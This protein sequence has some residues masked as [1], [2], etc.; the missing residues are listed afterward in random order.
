MES[1]EYNQKSSYKHNS[2]KDEEITVGD[3]KMNLSEFFNNPKVKAFKQMHGIEFSGEWEI[4][5]TENAQIFNDLNIPKGRIELGFENDILSLSELGYSSRKAKN[6][7]IKVI[8]MEGNYQDDKAKYIEVSLLDYETFNFSSSQY[9]FSEKPVNIMMFENMETKDM[10]Q[11]NVSI[12]LDLSAMIHFIQ[13]EAKARHNSQIHSIDDVPLQFHLT[14]SDCGFEVKSTLYKDFRDL[15]KKTINYSVLLTFVA[16]IHLYSIAKMIKLC[17]DSPT[18]AS[19]ISLITIGFILIWDTYICL[20]HLFTALRIEKLFH[21]FIMPTFW[22]FILFSIFETKLLII[23][24]KARYGNLYQNE[25]QSRRALAN[26]YFKLYTGMVIILYLL[27]EY[28]LSN[29]FVLVMSL[30]LVPQIIHN[31]MKGGRIEFDQN[32][33]FNIIGLR[34]LLPLYF[35]GCPENLMLLR[36]SF[37]FCS[38][39]IAIVGVQVLLVYYQSIYGS[40]FFVPSRFLPK[41]YNYLV[42]IPE[43]IENGGEVDDCAICMTALH[44]PVEAQTPSNPHSRMV[45]SRLKPEKNQIMKTPCNHKFHVSCL[46]EWMSIKME[47]PTC[48]SALPVLE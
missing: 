33:M 27:Y 46:V 30:Y 16:I 28:I 36:P 31:A 7:T 19:Q 42:E 40:K 34:I 10:L 25:E 15:E 44:Q 11:C 29:W 45:L 1:A 14:S 20:A 48:R 24:W 22:Y 32:Y 41:Q 9:S 43:D 47:C 18:K 6:S 4:T 37:T 26:F 17:L 39:L 35:R 13:E 8:V 5:T 12:D 21:F 23:I 38:G 2:V 3:Q